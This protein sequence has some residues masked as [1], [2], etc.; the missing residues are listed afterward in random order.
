MSKKDDKKA[1]RKAAAKAARKAAKRAA[2]QTP[3]PAPSPMDK[4]SDFMTRHAPSK[5]D[6]R[7]YKFEISVVAIA[8]GLVGLAHLG[9]LM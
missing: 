9:G 7:W 1:A 3:A 6:L 4:V 8:T 2:Q 5:T